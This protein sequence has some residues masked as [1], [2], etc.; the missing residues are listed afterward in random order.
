MYSSQ[1]HAVQLL[2]VGFHVLRDH[3]ACW[4]G[5]RL[6]R[7]LRGIKGTL[8]RRSRVAVGVGVLF[9]AWIWHMGDSPQFSS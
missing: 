2:A 8:S 9:C 5:L 3:T 1:L 7:D 6:P 4:N